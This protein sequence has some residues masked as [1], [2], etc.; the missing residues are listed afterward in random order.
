MK[1]LYHTSRLCFFVCLL[2]IN[3]P[4]LQGQQAASKLGRL[5]QSTQG[6]K[7]YLGRVWYGAEQAQALK[8]ESLAAKSKAAQSKTVPPAQGSKKT[9]F[10]ESAQRMRQSPLG[11]KAG[12]YAQQAIKFAKENPV[13]TGVGIAVL[14][15]A[16]VIADTV[17]RLFNMAMFDE[18]L[19]SDEFSD[20]IVRIFNTQ[21]KN[22]SEPDWQADSQGS[23]FIVR[24]EKNPDLYF[25]ITAAHCVQDEDFQ[26]VQIKH[27]RYPNTYVYIKVEP[28]IIDKA[29]DVAILFI[30]PEQKKYFVDIT[31]DS[32]LPAIP[33]KQLSSIR[34]RKKEAAILQ[35][36]PGF[37]PHEESRFYRKKFTSQGPEVVSAESTNVIGLPSEKFGAWGRK[38]SL[39]G[40]SG[41]P[42][43][44]IRDNK[45]PQVIGVASMQNVPT[46]T[47]FV[48]AVGQLPEYI[49]KAERIQE[50][51]SE[52]WLGYFKRS[53]WG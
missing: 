32:L 28:I 22:F 34:P 47:I 9:F 13:K 14:T 5:G 11:Q 37:I 21:E 50:K 45:Q 36:Y 24:G 12:V 10:K 1:K 26:F 2:T 18:D 20:A 38:Q 51:E 23:A 6:L 39:K 33:A 52:G 17:H 42:M 4:F 27:T 15:E 49:Q 35:G 44:A 25:V 43:I 8:A 19:V 41:G 53:L 29:N 48:S 30:Q 40:V 31:G 46:K 7:N 16:H 3:M